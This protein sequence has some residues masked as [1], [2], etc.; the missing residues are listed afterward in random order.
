MAVMPDAKQL[1]QGI[2][3]TVRIKRNAVWVWRMK[4]GAWL[5][6]LAAWIMWTALEMEIVD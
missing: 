2:M 3:L 1:A 6:R 5:I 4:I